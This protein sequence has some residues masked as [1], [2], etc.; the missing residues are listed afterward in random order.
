MCYVCQRTFLL[1]CRTLQNC[2]KIHFLRQKTR[3]LRKSIINPTHRQITTVYWR[4]LTS[5]SVVVKSDR[6]TLLFNFAATLNYTTTT[7]SNI[8]KYKPNPSTIQIFI[9][10]IEMRIY[11]TLT[12]IS[13]S[14]NLPPLLRS[15]AHQLQHH[16]RTAGSGQR[17]YNIR[18][19]KGGNFGAGWWRL[20]LDSKIEQHK[21]KI[22]IKIW[23]QGIG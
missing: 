20:L 8:L 7:L 6:R 11:H 2:N 5:V 16:I 4:F 19:K 1:Q 17:K 18:T 14:W 10:S 3:N 22:K 21:S 12:L 9:N 13:S 15:W 23:K